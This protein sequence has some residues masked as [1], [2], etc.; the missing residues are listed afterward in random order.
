MSL[1]DDDR[2]RPA[3]VP[4]PGDD[5]SL[6]SIAEIEERIDIFRDEIRRLEQALAAKRDSLAAAQSVFRS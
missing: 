2:P 1:S 5:L 4:R 6:L 3:A